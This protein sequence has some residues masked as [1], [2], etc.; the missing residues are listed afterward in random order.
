MPK[1][2][3]ELSHFNGQHSVCVVKTS[4]LAVENQVTFIS[5]AYIKL[6]EILDFFLYE[7]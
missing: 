3:H 6:N 1:I 5:I 4:K 7:Q 2:N